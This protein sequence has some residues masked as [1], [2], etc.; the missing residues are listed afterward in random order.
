MT[1]KQLQK[2]LEDYGLE[3]ILDVC[4]ITYEDALQVLLDEGL[5]ILPETWPLDVQI[6]QEQLEFEFM[7]DE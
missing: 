2:I 1:S 6:E 3:Y 5:V 4:Q 7:Q